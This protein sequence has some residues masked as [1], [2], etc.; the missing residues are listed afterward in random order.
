MYYNMNYNMN[1]TYKK[2][3]NTNYIIDYN[4]YIFGFDLDSTLIKFLYS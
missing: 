2:Y 4:K 1:N 3:N